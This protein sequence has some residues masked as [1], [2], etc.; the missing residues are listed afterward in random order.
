[1]RDRVLPPAVDDVLPPM[2]CCKGVWGY[3][4]AATRPECRNYTVRMRDDDTLTIDFVLHES[5]VASNW[6][7]L[8]RPATASSSRAP[9]PGTGV[10]RTPRGNCSW[11][12]RRVCRPS[13]EH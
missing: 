1:M 4:D 12:T 13:P 3:H 7:R 5:G 2:T 11:R 8:A 6:A 9:A 10:P